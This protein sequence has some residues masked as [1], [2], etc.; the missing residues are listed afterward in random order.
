MSD[1][2]HSNQPTD[3]QARFWSELVQLKAHLFYLSY[4]CRR[5]DQFDFWIKCL[6]AIASSSS[7]AAWGIQK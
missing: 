1:G 2:T 4:Q 5:A 6:T 7:I 3:Q